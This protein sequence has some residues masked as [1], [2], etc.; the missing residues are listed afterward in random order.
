[1]RPLEEVEKEYII[2]ALAQNGGNQTHTAEQLQIGR[3]RC[4]ASS[5]AT[6]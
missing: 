5:R 4:T 6:G 1:V 3:R 2:A